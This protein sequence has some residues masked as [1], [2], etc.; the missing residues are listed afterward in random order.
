MQLLYSIKTFDS[1]MLQYTTFFSCG[2][3][4]TEKQDNLDHHHHHGQAQ[5]QIHMPSLTA[6][7]IQ[8]SSSHMTQV[9]QPTPIF[10]STAQSSKLH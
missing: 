4:F 6:A 7:A 5:T 3:F 2:S 8:H 1:K 9:S 10:I